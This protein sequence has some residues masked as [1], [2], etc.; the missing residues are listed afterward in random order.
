MA[1][2]RN[3]SI[4]THNGCKVWGFYRQANGEPMKEP[5]TVA[6]GKP[7]VWGN[8]V[9][10]ATPIIVSPDEAGRYEVLLPPS[11]VLGDYVVTAGRQQLTVRVPEGVASAAL[12]TLLVE[13]Q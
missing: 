5:I 12:T 10:D 11:A 9:Y 7:G 13:E 1:K 4:E 6:P 8:T 2:V 3:Q